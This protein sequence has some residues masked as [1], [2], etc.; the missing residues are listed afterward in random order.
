MDYETSALAAGGSGDV[1]LQHTAEGRDPRRGARFAAAKFRPMTLPTTLVERPALLGQLTAGAGDRLT[2]V[3][4]SAGAGKSVLL[5][6]WAASREPGCTS[7]LSCDEADAD[8]ARFW[9]GF[10]EALRGIAPG[11][12]AEASELLAID[13]A[14]SADATASIADDAAKLPAGS[15]IVVDD[16]HAA[17]SAA[18]AMTDLIERWPASTAQL[19]LASRVDQP[20]RLH[21][22]RLSGELRELRDRDLYLSLTESR[23]LLG[24]F[25]V[26]VADDELELL[27]RRTEG[28]AAALQMAALT[29][30]GTEDAAQVARALDVRGHTIAE[31]FIDEVLDRLPADLAQFMLDTSG[32][33]ELTAE[34][35]TAVT[36]RPDAMALLRT[37]DA[38]SLFIVAL[39]DDRMSYRYHHLVRQILRAELRARDRT[40]E[41]A[42]HLRAAEWLESTRD[43]R[44]AT[45][46]FLAA[47]QVD[48]A[49]ALLQEHVA[50]DFLH[51]PE[52]AALDLSFVDPALLMSAPDRLLALA[53]HLLLWGD[54]ARGG[55]YL[56]LLGR[57]QL[58]AAPDSRL[59]AR[60]AAMQALRHALVGEA[61][62][63]RRH[64]LAARNIEER[65]LPGDEWNAAVPLILLR[66][67]TWLDD[68]DAVDREAATA[69]GM[70]SLAGPAR[71]VDARGA[72]AIAWFEAGR[73]ADA[74]KAAQAAAA[75]AG[76]LGFDQH[77]FAAEY[78]R[79]LA[80][81]ALE[82][83]DLDSAEHLTERALSIAERF[84]PVFEFLALL[85]RAWV[86][87][88]RGQTDA[89]L[90]TTD[91]ARHVLAGRKSSLTARADEQ[92]ALLR[93]ALGDV[94]SP[95]ALAGGLA[96]TR[97][98][99]LLARVALATGDHRTAIDHLRAPSMAALTPRAA[100]VRQILLAGAAIQGGDP[101]AA[102]MMNGVLEAA[103]RGGFLNT[104]V[105]TAPQ[106]TG[107]LV[108]HATQVRPDPFLQQLVVAALEVRATRQDSSA[109]HGTTVEPMTPAELRI[110]KLLPT[111]TYLQIGD[112]LYISRNTVKSH[113]RS[114]Y[115]KL[116]VSSRSEAIERAV[117]LQLL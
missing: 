72:Q 69:L 102:I 19:V 18:A 55:H 98:Q 61:D 10:I 117:Q 21:R 89:A 68:V 85:D 12:G 96:P 100:L 36:G 40:R 105:T 54:V 35:C 99:L 15:A 114:I 58:A 50:A 113:L 66:A 56:D 8:P 81:A 30:R 71:L 31:Y 107:Y 77:P 97:R 78:L 74:V 80:G 38:A 3:V 52:P 20:L 45:R 28:W 92:E 22:L 9:A 46:H 53:A 43:T 111:S 1:V 60:L 62:E 101:T 82:R 88:A 14:M 25:G 44:R 86:W 42:L 65:A 17:A 112:A 7:W 39:D 33:D 103:R 116:G 59:A 2:V 79:V 106:V 70:P 104:V 23:D 84:R 108:E 76:R 6:N 109:P 87:A 41:L 47:Q 26:Q 73:L 91:A 4:G 37:M 67:Y 49:L 34:A 115:Q 93:L 94:R 48:R 13:G 5:S 63:A 24:N 57:T 16:F 75:A 11:F 29:L 27:H 64:A 90:A 51:D 95:V 32:L 83:R 110:L